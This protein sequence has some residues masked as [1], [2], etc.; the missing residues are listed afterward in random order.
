MKKRGGVLN[1]S[2][3][4]RKTNPNRICFYLIILLVLTG[5][6]LIGAAG[7]AYASSCWTYSSS[8]CTAANGCKWRNDSW[9][10]TGW[11]EDLSCWSL[12]TQNE[13]TSTPITGKNC[14]WQA[15]QT[16]YWCEKLDCWSLS[17]TNVSSCTNNS[18]GLSCSWANQCYNSGT[19]PGGVWVDCWS[20]N[21]QAGCVN[22]SGCSWGQCNSK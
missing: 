15:G 18:L 12:Y 21:N 8:T 22:T 19:S 7:I 4:D 11:C 14:T 9:S 16:N 20:I 1:V 5:I 3:S 6:I 17:G 2:A 13:C 10:T